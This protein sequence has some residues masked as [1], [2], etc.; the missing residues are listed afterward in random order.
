MEALLA[1]R[2][3]S[4][5]LARSLARLCAD[6]TQRDGVIAVKGHYVLMGLLGAGPDSKTTEYALDALWA[7]A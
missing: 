3:E 1:A 4:E 7:M 2:P 5:E 6:E